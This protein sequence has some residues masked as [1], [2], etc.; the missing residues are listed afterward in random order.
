MINRPRAC[1][2][3]VELR[4]YTLYSGQRDALIALFDREFVE[5]Q[6]AVGM[7]VI[8]QFRDLDAPDRFVWLRG[9]TDMESRAK[10]LTE[11]YGGPVWAVHRQAAAATMVDSDNVL[12]LQ[13]VDVGSGLAHPG[14][15]RGGVEPGPSLVEVSVYSISG[16]EKNRASFVAFYVERLA[17]LL[18]ASGAPPIAWFVTLEAENTFPALP[19]RTGENVLVSLARFRDA[20]DHGAH[21]RRL[22]ESASWT[23]E[24]EP[25]LATRLSGP[26]QRL[27]LAPTSRSELR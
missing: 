7:H 5:T 25:A 22:H 4:Q 6:E 21:V 10:S 16:T 11:F 20:D 26:V 8:G 1:C 24:V 9:F 19:V 15:P 14:P 17:P 2:S 3:V 18:E 23:D 12:L 27:R 13:P